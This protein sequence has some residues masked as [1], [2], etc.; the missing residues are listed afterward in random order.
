MQLQLFLLY[1]F[2]SVSLRSHVCIRIL[3]LN[4]GEV[5]TDLRNR[6]KLV[7]FK[8]RLLNHVAIFVISFWVVKM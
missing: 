1:T 8:V 3:G 2:A 4:I 6:R 7:S 5:A